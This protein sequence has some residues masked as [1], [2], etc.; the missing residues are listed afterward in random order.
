MVVET[1][2]LEK[3]RIEQAYKIMQDTVKFAQKAK[4]EK[5]YPRQG[6]QCKSVRDACQY[7]DLCFYFD[8]IRQ[9]PE[10][11]VNEN[12]VEEILQLYEQRDPDEHLGLEE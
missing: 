12:Y 1:I 7:L 8:P 3:N 9:L 2:L 4:D 10:V 11:G 6:T 5:F